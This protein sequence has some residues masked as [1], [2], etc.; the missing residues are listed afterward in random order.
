MDYCF[1]CRYSNF[2]A[3]T[4]LI[5]A[6]SAVSPGSAGVPPAHTDDGLIQ[7]AGGTPVLPG[8]TGQ[9]HFELRVL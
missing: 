5:L 9:T 6:A 8:F 3:I 1:D 2:T 7:L 4:K